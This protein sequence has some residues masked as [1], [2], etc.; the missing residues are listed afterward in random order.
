MVRVI[1]G[2][3]ALGL[4]MPVGAQAKG[5]GS[6]YYEWQYETKDP[7]HGYSGFAGI[8][9]GRRSLYCDY[10]RLPNR[11]CITLKSGKQRCK[12]VSWT[13]KQMCQ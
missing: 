2:L 9:N 13:L 10:H 5:K 12:V 6:S 7:V 3:L 4:L 8:G 11:E 1:C